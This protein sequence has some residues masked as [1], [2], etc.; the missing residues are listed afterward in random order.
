MTSSSRVNEVMKNI[1]MNQINNSNSIPDSSRRDEDRLARIT[2]E[3]ERIAQGGTH[4]FDDTSQRL[5]L[6][7]FEEVDYHII[8]VYSKL[9]VHVGVLCHIG[10]SKYSGEA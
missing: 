1:G 5:L 10:A 6:S 4:E 7:Y 2:R 3:Q 8:N 9:N